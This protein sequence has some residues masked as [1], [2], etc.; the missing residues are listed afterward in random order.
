MGLRAAEKPKTVQ[1]RVSQ[2][3]AQGVGFRVYG[4][5][6]SAFG[7]GPLV[8][9]WVRIWQQAISSEFVA[10]GLRSLAMQ[11]V[12]SHLWFPRYSSAQMSGILFGH[13]MV[14]NIE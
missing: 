5:E 7:G 1:L 2:F 11:L 9:T 12:G 13:T 3:R 6:F 14:P 8:I 10:M 4:L